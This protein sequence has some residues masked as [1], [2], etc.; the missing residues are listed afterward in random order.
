MSVTLSQIRQ[1][2][3]QIQRQIPGVRRAFDYVPLA[4]PDSDLPAFCNFVGPASFTQ[5]GDVVGEET[6]IWIM[7]L[8]VRPVLQG[9]DGETEKSVDQ[10]LTGVR[11]TFLSHPAF[12]LGS[13]AS[14][15]P[16]VKRAVW[17]GDNGIQVL[18][19]A[20]QS[21]LGVEFRLAVTTTIL[22]G[23]SDYE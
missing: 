12:G 14:L 7:R 16:E 13:L 10:F 2:L 8:Y 3:V 15:L 17:Q 19:F 18:D 11:N 5:T 9:I 20:G 1:R 22:I 6:R 4:L 21:Y 23:Y